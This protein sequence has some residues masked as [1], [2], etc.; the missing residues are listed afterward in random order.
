V[1]E[2]DPDTC[3]LTLTKL[4]PGATLAQARAATGWELAV[5]DPLPWTEPPTDTELEVLRALV[6]GSSP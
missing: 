6:K 3:E 5:A 2:P 4:H 1:L